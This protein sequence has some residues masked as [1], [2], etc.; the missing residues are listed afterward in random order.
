M[1]YEIGQTTISGMKAVTKSDE[2]A[3]LSREL[4]AQLYNEIHDAG[5]RE[6]IKVANTKGYIAIKAKSFIAAKITVRKSS[7]KIEVKSEFASLFS[8]LEI[9]DDAKEAL[10]RIVLR[11]VDEVFNFIP[12][13]SIIAVETLAKFGGESFGCCGRYEECSDARQCLH[14]DKLYARACA[15]R[16]NLENGK[17]FYGK[18]KTI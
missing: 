13:L 8:G 10:S 16:K 12:Q 18:N 2:V 4:T 14:P 3:A 6:H 15:Y 11:N 9:E 17:I 1:N 5:Y 7:V